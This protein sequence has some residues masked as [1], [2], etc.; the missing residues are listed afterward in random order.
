MSPDLDRGRCTVSPL[1]S[2]AARR[3]KARHVTVP[4]SRANGRVRPRSFQ[5]AMVRRCSR[6]LAW[7]GPRLDAAVKQRRSAT[8]PLD[9][10][11]RGRICEARDHALQSRGGR[12]PAAATFGR[13]AAE[14][15]QRVRAK[16]G[17]LQK[18]RTEYGSVNPEGASF[19]GRVSGAVLDNEAHVI[20][21][22]HAS[23]VTGR[24][25]EE[26]ASGTRLAEAVRTRSSGGAKRRRERPGTQSR[27]RGAADGPDL[28]SAA[29]VDARRTRAR[30]WPV[31]LLDA[32]AMNARISSPSDYATLLMRRA[33]WPSSL[34]PA[35][36]R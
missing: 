32:R 19:V 12:K 34:Q 6:G 5:H 31:P 28:T 13:A 8:L 21:K 22:R 7:R 17:L 36:R 35:R 15:S 20:G 14:F 25:S 4:S 11:G 29:H 24:R 1:F 16:P 33:S 27:S 30:A 9:A 3:A 23:R 26:V 18:A 10:D 2:F